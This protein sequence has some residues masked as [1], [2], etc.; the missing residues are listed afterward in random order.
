MSR[1][2]KQKKYQRQD[3]GLEN[4]LDGFKRMTYDELVRG[5]FMTC[6]Y[7]RLPHHNYKGITQGYCS[8]K[9]SNCLRFKDYKTGEDCNTYQKKF[10]R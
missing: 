10:R 4:K 3:N 8:L 6:G 5:P 1:S 2:K 9:K 7:L